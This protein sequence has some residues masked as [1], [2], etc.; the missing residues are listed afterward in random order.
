MTAYRPTW[1]LSTIPDDRLRSEWGRRNSGRR[2]VKRGGTSGGRH[3]QPTP[4][5]KCGLPCPS[6]GAAIMHCRKL[7]LA[8]DF[9]LP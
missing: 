6:V 4:C 7:P 9:Y 3:P 1:D 2:K 8:F 5:G